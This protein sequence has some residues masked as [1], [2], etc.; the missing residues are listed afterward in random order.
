MSKDTYLPP[1]CFDQPEQAPER[2]TEMFVDIVQKKR[3]DLGQH[4]AERA[5]FRKLHGV[6][7]GRLEMCKDIPDELKV[8]VFAHQSLQAW[9]RF[10]SDT[11]PTSPDLGSTLGIG[12]K[13]F[14]VPGPKALGDDGDT[15]DFIMQNFPV[16]F[17]D[18]AQEMVE[19]TYAGVVAQDYPGYL[20]KHPK[21][22]DILNRM[23]RTI[24]GSVLTTQ[25]WA[26]LPFHSGEQR[27]VKFRLDPETPAE[28]VANNQLDYLAVDLGQ[29]LSQREYRFRF[30]VQLRTNDA[31]MPLD[32]ATVEWPEAE[33]PF[34]HVATLTLAQQ[35]VSER[36][37]AEYGQGLGFNIWRLP[38]EQTPVGSIA[39]ARKMAYAAGAHLR[40]EANGQSL[41]DPPQPRPARCPFAP[42]A[43][44]RV[45]RPEPEVK[46]QCIVKAVIYPAIGVAR[47]GN[48]QTEWF[49]GPEV[50]NP[51]PEKPGFYRDAKKALKRQAARFRVYG[52]NAKG[53]IVREL[54]PDNAKIQWQV[55]LANT[56]AA[57]YGFQLALD[58]PEAASAPPSTL[59]NAAVADRT[60]LAITPKA[61]SVTGKDSKVQ[62]FD[63]GQFMGTPVYLGEIFTDKQGRLVVLGGHGVSAS[64][65]DSRAITFANNEGWHDD[66]SDGP[67]TAQ[68]TLDGKALLVDPAWIIVGPPNFGPQRKSVRTMWDLMRDVAIDAGTL[69]CPSRPS[70]TLEILPIFER[71]A[72]LQWVNAGFAAGFGWKGVNDLSSPE[73]LARLADGSTANHDWRHSIANQ[74]RNYE[75]DSWSPKPW[76]WI[77]GD[78]MAVPAAHTPRQNSTLGKTQ[79][80]LLWEWAAGNFVEDYDPERVW[81]Q[82]IDNV[83]LAERGDT[84]TRAALEFCLAD[85]FHPGCEIT[86]PVRSSTMYMAPFRL[87]HA[88]D[89]W[90]A[91]GLGEVFTSDWLTIPNGPLYGQQA[92]G[93]TRWMAVPWQTD[94]AS[95]RSG[96]DKNYDPYVP[97]FWPA[98]VPNEVL[99]KHNYRIVMDEEK[100]LGERLAAFANRAAWIDPLGSTSYTD[101]I[102]NMIHHF[103]HLGVVEVHPGPSDREHF[104]AVIEVEDQHLPIPDQPNPSAKPH[105]TS[106][107]HTALQVGAITGTRAESVDI[108]TIEKVRRFP[109]GLPG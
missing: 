61:R 3:I 100:P 82:D 31:S 92:G 30:M 48:S 27:Y 56:K 45:D 66:V 51:A 95:C 74:F 89:G 4:P 68:V 60:R 71:M 44:T 84:L 57:W 52:V 36:G 40:H 12:I 5:V 18:N 108:M 50:P 26:I 24:E 102:N 93:L 94:S 47:V 76:P 105:T 49:V 13:L 43:D 79:M 37:Q 96:Y 34:V 28:N 67:V 42:A 104:P 86:W 32:Q 9:V 65:D 98:R 21:T 23:G 53:E 16:F 14:G 72:G 99:T 33:S 25:Y 20:K 58:I 59:R 17:V 78:A 81:P 107:E 7:H 83:P 11:T 2:L 91:P 10:S 90:V 1:P 88:L 64:W 22:N 85:A 97:S 109:R 87:A 75:V 63:D 69:A 80:A 8:G 70:F 19:F 62:R 35:D 101:Q 103:D 6:A 41:Q 106:E 38:L 54:T 39:E 73:T 46:D 15:A 55:Q 29:R 77:Y